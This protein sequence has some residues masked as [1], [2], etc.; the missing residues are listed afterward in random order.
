MLSSL[1]EHG[2]FARTF[3]ET[4]VKELSYESADKLAEIASVRLP[5]WRRRR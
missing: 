5:D 2:H 4:F 1:R 3:L